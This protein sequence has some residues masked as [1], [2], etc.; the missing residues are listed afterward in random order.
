MPG[1]QG[2]WVRYEEAKKEIDRL[3]TE[4]KELREAL[5]RVRKAPAEAYAAAYPAQVPEQ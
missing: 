2:D 4:N 3:E 1:L 5:D